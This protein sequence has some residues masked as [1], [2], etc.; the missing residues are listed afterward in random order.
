MNAF[1]AWG[2]SPQTGHIGF[3]SRL[4]YEHQSRRIKAPLPLMPRLARL[5]YVLAVLLA[6]P[7]CLFLYV[8]PMSAST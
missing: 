5:R 3:G 2:T 6:R 4:V 7:E 8:R 1:S